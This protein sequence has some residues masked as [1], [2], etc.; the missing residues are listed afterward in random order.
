MKKKRVMDEKT[1][2]VE[3]VRGNRGTSKTDVAVGGNWDRQS[4]GLILAAGERSGREALSSRWMGRW[5]GQAAGP[6]S[7]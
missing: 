4:Q 1:F 3:K 5:G 6:L 2:N 7:L